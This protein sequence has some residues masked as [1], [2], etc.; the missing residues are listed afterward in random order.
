[1]HLNH[2]PALRVV[3]MHRT[4]AAVASRS[5]TIAQLTGA[6]PSHSSQSNIAAQQSTSRRHCSSGGN[7][8]SADGVHGDARPGPRHGRT[9]VQMLQDS[10]AQ[11]AQ[12]QEVAASISSP[13][14]SK[15]VRSQTSKLSVY[16]CIYIV[17][18]VF[19]N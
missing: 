7:L 11:K 4:P 12:N 16:T 13:D 6:R 10:L 15:V 5:L 1:M 3:E 17:L 2:E 14:C 9:V 19:D 18:F 8:H